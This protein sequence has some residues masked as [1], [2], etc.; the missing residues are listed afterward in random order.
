MLKGQSRPLWA[1]TTCR[2]LQTPVVNIKANNTEKLLQCDCESL[3]LRWDKHTIC[4]CMAGKR[5]RGSGRLFLFLEVALSFIPGVCK[6][7]T[8]PDL[9]CKFDEI[10]N[11]F[12]VSIVCI[13]CVLTWICVC[14][15]NANFALPVINKGLLALVK[16]TCRENK[17][18]PALSYSSSAPMTFLAAARAICCCSRWWRFI[19]R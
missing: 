11:M 12:R 4:L 10:H 5:S 14:E 18:N 8:S 16:Q 1:S 2:A 15:Q 9:C 17:W 7:F 6:C 13:V 19:F 3:R